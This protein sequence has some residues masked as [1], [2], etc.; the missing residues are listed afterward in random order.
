MGRY[1]A[2][3]FKNAWR[4]RRRTILT[5]LSVGASLCLLGVLMAVYHAFYFTEASPAQARRLITRNRVS[6]AFSM[7]VYYAERIR[8]VPGV[9][10]V[11][12][13]QWFNG[14][15]RDS[16]DPNNFFARMGIEPDKLFILRPEMTLPPEEK[17]AF[18]HERTACLV[19][20]PLAARHNLKTGDRVTLIGD[21]FPVT[22][23]L[24][25]RGVYDAPDNAEI[26]Y[27][28]WKYLEESISPGR[29]S[30][31]GAFSILAE[32]PE[33]VPAVARGVDEMFRNAPVQTRT[34]S[35]QQFALSF[36]SLLGNVKFF[37]LS[38]CGAV[39]FTVLLVS[40][41]TMAMSVRERVREV[42][43][44]KTLGFTRGKILGM[45]LAEA[46]AISLAGGALGLALA[47]L[48]CMAIRHGPVPFDMV[49]RLSVDPSVAA[50]SLAIAAAIGVVSS[51]APAWNAARITIIDA[52]RHGG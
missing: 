28:H 25:V 11:G 48:L 21:I 2:F 31:V 34:E 3:V 33:A 10:E 22:L 51:L 45:V 26:L 1:G 24:T 19:G 8:Q 12:M 42:G 4:N 15:F 40:A 41:N 20:R 27:F 52:I 9:R 37:L 6:L 14:T 35:E 50:L 46:A 17:D 47:S 13:S 7:P 32:S 29:R 49:R 36:L 16:R 38:V 39:T 30:S 23:E 5:V 44:L 18:L 43:I